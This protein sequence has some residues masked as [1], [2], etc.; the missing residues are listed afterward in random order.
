LRTF[1]A[2]NPEKMWLIPSVIRPRVGMWV[3]LGYSSPPYPKI[4][5]LK[6]KDW[7]NWW[8]YIVYIITSINWVSWIQKSKIWAIPRSEMFW[9][10]TL[11]PKWKIPHH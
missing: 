11:C 10:P 4:W 7:I 6:H 1:P 9:A 5:E 3:K 8:I 2:K